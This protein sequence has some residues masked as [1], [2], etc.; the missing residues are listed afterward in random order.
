A[1]AGV[2]QTNH[3]FGAFPLAVNWNGNRL[4]DDTCAHRSAPVIGVSSM[5]RPK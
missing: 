5:A 4:P 2:G 1:L 3:R